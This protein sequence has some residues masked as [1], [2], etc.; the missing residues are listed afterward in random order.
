MWIFISSHFSINP[1]LLHNAIASIVEG[2]LF[3]P[4]C[5]FP[6]EEQLKNQGLSVILQK[7]VKIFNS[8]C[9]LRPNL[10]LVAGWSLYDED[11]KFFNKPLSQS[12]LS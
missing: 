12:K 5:N 8:N 11:V 10:S 3:F 9:E 6:K 1:L 7:N 2:I 4:P